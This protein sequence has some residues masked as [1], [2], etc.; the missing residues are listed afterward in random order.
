M[1]PLLTTTMV[2]AATGRYSTIAAIKGESNGGDH[3]LEGLRFDENDIYTADDTHLKVQEKS[4]A[5]VLSAFLMAKG[6]TCRL[7]AFQL[8][9]CEFAVG[10]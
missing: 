7:V 6:A 1:Q 10:L 2:G 5:Q 4:V 8:G 9:A 3:T